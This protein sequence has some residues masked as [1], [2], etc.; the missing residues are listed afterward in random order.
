[1]PL[2][3]LGGLVFG[4]GLAVSHMARPEVVLDFLQFDDLGLLLVMAAG[5]AVTGAVF[6]VATRSG[7]TAP[8]TGRAY[9]LRLRDLDSNVVV[10]GAVFGVG[11]GL[12]GICPGATY[13]SLGIG[14]Y[15]I[16]LAIAGMFGGAYLHGWW[17]S[18]RADHGEGAPSAAD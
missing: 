8:L 16:L 12:S 3:F 9:G 17:R 11:W 2:V 18:Y 14:N 10:G 4:L 1:M 7:R 13:A 6:A 5:T 15:P